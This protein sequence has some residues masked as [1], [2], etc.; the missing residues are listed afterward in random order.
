MRHPVG[1]ELPRSSLGVRLCE[2]RVA[3]AIVMPPARE[4]HLSRL[5]LRPTRRSPRRTRIWPRGYDA[6]VSR[7]PSLGPRGEGWVV[8]QV[9]LLVALAAAGMWLRPSWSGALQYLA[10]FAGIMA[11]AGGAILVVRGLVDLRGA[12]TPL[13][14]P[15]DDAQLV[16]TGVYGLARHPIYGSLILGSVGWSLLQTSL[17]ALVVSAAIAVFLILKS[18]R[19]ETWLM[20]QYAGYAAYR[21]RTRRFIPWIC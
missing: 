9:V 5:R 15:R 14:R 4:S 13:P 1:S 3:P 16:E 21:T 12:L 18:S 2:P 8:I 11:L 17:A 19:E 10:I 6:R 20:E 7:L